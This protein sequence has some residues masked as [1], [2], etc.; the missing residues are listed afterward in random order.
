MLVRITL[1]LFLVL[2]GLVGLGWTVPTI[3]TAVL[4]LIAG[5]A[6]LIGI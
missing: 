3:L 2:V 4:A 5:L 6:T 1:G